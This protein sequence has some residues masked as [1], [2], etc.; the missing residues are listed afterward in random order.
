MKVEILKEAG[1]EEALLGMSLSFYDY[2]Q[3]IDEWWPLQKEKAKDRAKKLAH[4]QGGHNKFIE[5]I[6]LWI[7]VS[8][9]LSWWKHADTYRM[10]SKQSAS[11]MHT[12]KKRLPLDKKD[13]AEHVHPA[14]INTFNTIVKDE[15]DIGVIADNL[16][17]GFLQTRIWK[18]SYKTLQNVLAQREGHRLKHWEDFG[19]QIMEQVEY[20]ELLVKL[21]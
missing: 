8:A 13:F 6:E 20:P 5:H 19:N 18:M 17:D 12:I 3:P 14:M 10:A 2:T 1:Y 16:P 15:K 21:K 4:M 9:P 11:T 7:M